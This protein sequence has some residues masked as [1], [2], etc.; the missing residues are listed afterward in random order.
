MKPIRLV[1]GVMTV[2]FWTLM[3]RVLGVVREILILGLIGPG[4]VMDAF[5]AAFRLPNLFRRFF[6]EGAFNAAFVPLFSKKYEGEEDPL[7]F[8]RDALNGLATVLLALTALAM[9]F[10]PALVWATAGGFAGDARFDLTVGF[11]RIVFPYILLI[12]LAALFSGALNAT[13]HFAAA[14]AAPVLL[15]IL[16]CLS[17]ALGA[18][19]EGDVILYLVWTVPVA[20]VAQLALV[21]VAADRAGVRI[22]PGLPRLTPDM[23]RL[24]VIA[25]PAALAGG[26]MQ[27]NLLVGQQVASHFEKAVGWLYAADRLYQLPLG[28]VGIAVGIVLLPD[29][30][31]RLKAQDDTGARNAF[32]RAGELSLALT[33]PAAVALVAIPLP[34]VSVLFERGATTANDSAAIA[35]AV[36]IYG[37]GLPSFVLQKVLQPLYF[38]REDTRSPFRFAVWAMVVNAVIAVGLAPVI[39]WIAPAIATT[40]AGWIM[41]WQ[42]ARGA[43]AMGEV[44]HFDDRFRQRLW[45]IVAASVI[46]GAALWGFNLLLAPW[47]AVPYLRFAVLFG[48]ILSGVLVYGVAGQALGAFRLSEIKA[49]FKRS[50]G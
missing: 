9:V 34:M 37:L 3:S 12:S 11:G 8:A 29:L 42:L 49:M 23:K 21:W 35:L 28:V 47:L 38:A 33:V 22:R 25:V 45:R 1:A 14:A 24:V 44:A 17:M 2:G 36:A 7:I 19:L 10:M 32:S 48:L 18:A 13:G 6:A 16:V 43:R 46:M 4:P 39:G 40:L 26:V 5:V 20:G 15:N 41:V 50:R 30:S 31:R 27:I